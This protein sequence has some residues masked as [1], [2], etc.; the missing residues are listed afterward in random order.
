MRRMVRKGTLRK[1]EDERKKINMYRE[2]KQEKYFPLKTF[3]I[4][5]LNLPPPKKNLLFSFLVT[6]SFLR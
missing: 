6:V 5:L 3:S 2:E 4:Q 1:A